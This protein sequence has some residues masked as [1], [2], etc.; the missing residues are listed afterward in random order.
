M[1]DSIYNILALSNS[2]SV[3]SGLW[4]GDYKDLIIG[5][6]S[7]IGEKNKQKS[8]SPLVQSQ[9]LKTTFRII[10]KTK[11]QI[12]C[13]VSAQLISPFVYFAK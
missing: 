7:Y 2:I 11:A 12:S 6:C 9:Q 1:L 10:E 5:C 4:E 8:L 3:I 13:T